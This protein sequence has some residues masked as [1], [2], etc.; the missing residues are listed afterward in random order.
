MTTLPVVNKRIASTPLAIHNPKGSIMYSTHVANLDI[1][2]L[3]AA[4]RQVHI[5]PD[6]ASHTLLS[7][8]QLCDAGCD[9]TFNTN[10]VTVSHQHQLLLQGTRTAVTRLWHFDLPHPIPPPPITDERAMSAVGSA[11][12]AEL[13]AFAHAA[14]F[15]PALSTLAIALKK[16]F[17]QNFP[18]LTEKNTCKKSAALVRHGQRPHGPS[19][20]KLKLHLD[21]QRARRP[22]G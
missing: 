17:V 21:A 6:L 7:I 3:P 16:G 14:L 12:P 18:G 5:V 10:A 1:P 19:T 9:V 4:A 11:T 20:K 2:H 22:D 13:V 15:A 8:R